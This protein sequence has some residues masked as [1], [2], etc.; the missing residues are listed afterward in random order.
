MTEWEMKYYHMNKLASDLNIGCA[1]LQ[2]ERDGLRKAAQMALDSLLVCQE[3]ID[4]EWGEGRTNAQI[5]LAGD[6][7]PAITA[8]LKVLSE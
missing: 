7:D 5:E 4:G 1:R 6:T 3:Q 2:R 8:L